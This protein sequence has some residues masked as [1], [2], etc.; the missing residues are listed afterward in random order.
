MNSR[1][2]GLSATTGESVEIVKEELLWAG[3]PLSVELRLLCDEDNSGDYEL[4]PEE[5]LKLRWRQL[6][7]E[8]RKLGFVKQGRHDRF[9]EF[10]LGESS[11][12]ITHDGRMLLLGV[13]PADPRRALA[14]AAL[15]LTC[16]S[17]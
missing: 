17:Q 3:Q 8:L 7:Q 1:M 10:S 4:L 15:F 12:V 16:D 9:D 11:V 5:P 2:G 14:L 13:N 6:K